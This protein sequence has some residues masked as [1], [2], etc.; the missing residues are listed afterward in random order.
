VSDFLTLFA[1]RTHHGMF[2]TQRPGTA[3]AVGAFIALTV[4]TMLACFWPASS[5]D[6]LPTR[7]LAVKDP[8]NREGANYSLWALWIWIYCFIWFLIQD[9]IK[10]LLYWIMRK[11]NIFDINT[12]KMV[13]N[14]DATNFNNP[15]ARAS[16]GMVEGKLLEMKV[17]KTLDSVSRVARQ[18]NEPNLRRVSQDLTL[19]RNSVKLAR[20]SIGTGKPG[21]VEQ[22]AAA[23][24]L[25]RIQQMIGQMEGAVAAAPPEGKADIQKQLDELKATA[26]RLQAVDKLATTGRQ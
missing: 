20:Q 16:A 7:G 26:A 6:G 5:A 17:E 1:A 15:M 25:G 21:D 18:S 12:A 3:L 11:F 14:R 8:Q 2:Y 23:S 10:V 13:N 9:A 22:P 19:M 4:S 24:E